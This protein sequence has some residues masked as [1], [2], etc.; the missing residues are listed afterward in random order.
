MVAAGK[1]SLD[2]VD[3]TVYLVIARTALEKAQ[4]KKPIPVTIY[5]LKCTAQDARNGIAEYRGV[6]LYWD[7]A[8][9]TFN[10][11]LNDQSTSFR[12]CQSYLEKLK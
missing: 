9:A 5:D 3:L 2:K 8:T 12:I 1:S 10:Y 7:D 6:K 4:M 11:W